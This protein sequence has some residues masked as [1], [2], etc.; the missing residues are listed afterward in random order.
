[1][2]F[3]LLLHNVSASVPH[4]ELTCSH[5][6]CSSP[7]ASKMHMCPSGDTELFILYVILFARSSRLCVQTT[8][9]NVRAKMG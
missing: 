7:L 2:A 4:V 5:C 6:C 1:M 8:S 3:M 9:Q